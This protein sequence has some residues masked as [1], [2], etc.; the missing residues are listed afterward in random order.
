MSQIAILRERRDAA[1][2]LMETIAAEYAQDGLTDEQV[3]DID[4]RHADASADFH[5]CHDAADRLERAAKAAEA[6]PVPAE[7]APANV[8]VRTAAASTP[9]VR[10]V[11][12]PLTYERGNGRSFV[13]D[14]IAANQYRDEGALERIARHRREVEVERRDMSATDT[15]SMGEIIPPLWAVD[16]LAMLARAGRPFANQ[17]RSGPLPAG[18]DVIIIPQVTT[19]GSVHYQVT[20]NSAVAEQDM[21][22]GGTVQAAVKTIAGQLD[23][24][25][26]LLDQ[27]PLNVIDDIALPELYSLHA[28]QLETTITNG[29]GANGQLGGLFLLSGTNTTSYAAATPTAGSLYSKVAGAVNDVHTNRFLPPDLIVMH[30]RRWAFLLAASDTTG[31][32]L[33]LPAAS[34]PQNALGVFGGVVSEGIVGSMQGIPVCVSSAAIPTND[35]AGTTN[36]V[37]L[38]TRRQ[39]LMLWESS[40]RTRVLTEVLSG[41]LTVRVQLFNYVAATGGR[42]PDATSAVRGTGLATPSF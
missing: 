25:Q 33:V 11:K 20:Q 5:R 31:R 7:A 24:S 37:V 34:M 4:K 27:S 29:T 36:D 2:A 19:G 9:D 16:D 12:E 32:P 26:Q 30:P 1:L 18:T 14:M 10:V 35:G 21:V 22:T 39:D 17:W 6:S 28:N 3:A 23:F 13:R 8:E 42:Y 41:T 38:V 40:I 15:T